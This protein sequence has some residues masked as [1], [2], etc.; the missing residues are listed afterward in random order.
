MVDTTNAM[1]SHKISLIENLNCMPYA[2]YA[3]VTISGNIIRTERIY[4]NI[5]TNY[6]PFLLSCETDFQQ[7]IRFILSLLTSD[8]P[9]SDH[10]L[11]FFLGILLRFG[12]SYYYTSN[13]FWYYVEESAKCWLTRAF[14]WVEGRGGEGVVLW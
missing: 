12:I 8:V 13:F 14:V 11:G 4:G 5:Q 1:G 9:Y 7:D 10:T 6:T 2:V 3:T